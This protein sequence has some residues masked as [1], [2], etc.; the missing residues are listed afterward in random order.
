MGI[1]FADGNAMLQ[2]VTSYVSKWK[3]PYSNNTLYSH[4]VTPY[5]AA[6][7]H[8]KE[9]QPC[10][11]EMWLHMLPIKVSWSNSRTKSYSAP[12]SCTCATDKVQ[13]YMKQA[14]QM[15]DMSFLE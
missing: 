7:R 8:V 4:H 1:Q 3:D 5:Q 6:Y 13:I 10:D 14:K 12:T 11:P 15:E 9:M 2:Y